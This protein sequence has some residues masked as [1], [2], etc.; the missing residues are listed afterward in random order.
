[1]E[2]KPEKPSREPDYISKVSSYFWFEEMIY[3]A[4]DG[5]ICRITRD[6]ERGL[7][8]IR[9]FNRPCRVCEMCIVKKSCVRSYLA[10]HVQKAYYDHTNGW[11]EDVLLRKDNGQS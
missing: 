7:L 6:E 10:D 8:R 2:E 1:M 3:L 4:V 5:T 11:L 9:D